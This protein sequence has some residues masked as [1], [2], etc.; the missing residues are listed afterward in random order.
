MAGKWPLFRAAAGSECWPV[1][2]GCRGRAGLVM[3]ALSRT[4]HCGS[5]GP[6]V[7]VSE[8]HAGRCQAGL[9]ARRAWDGP[10]WDGRLPW[11]A[12][13][14]SRGTKRQARGP[15][16]GL[17][18]TAGGT[19]CCRGSHTCFSALVGNCG[20]LLCSDMAPETEERNKSQWNNLSHFSPVFFLL[21][22]FKRGAS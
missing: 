13:H 16:A 19:G 2:Q 10:G 4:G 8:M 6:Q 11:R 9:P 12:Q 18:L 22:F 7:C 5:L 15:E 1:P 3:W 17:E 20:H 21:E 14:F